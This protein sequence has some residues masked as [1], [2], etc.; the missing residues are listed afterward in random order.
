MW[1]K[2]T[3]VVGH[4][5]RAP[6]LRRDFTCW[7]WRAASLLAVSV[8]PG[9]PAA[10][11]PG[12]CRTTGRISHTEASDLPPSLRGHD[13]GNGQ[14]MLPTWG[15]VITQ[16][17]SRQV[18]R[19]V[20]NRPSNPELSRPDCN[21]STYLM[22]IKNHRGPERPLLLDDGPPPDG[23]RKAK[24]ESGGRDGGENGTSRPGTRWGENR[25][26]NRG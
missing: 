4:S 19:F 21:K 12:S 25:G 13:Q 16:V 24:G 26:R 18:G 11:P 2:I 9:T 6:T 5:V 23:R 7:C 15:N 3:V 17:D 14:R 22:R 8:C 1:W 10:T 20:A